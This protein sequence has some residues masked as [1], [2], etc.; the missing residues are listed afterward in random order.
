MR[1]SSIAIRGLLLPAGGVWMALVGLAA[2]MLAAGSVTQLPTR[3]LACTGLSVLWA[4]L[5]VAVV[6]AGIANRTEPSSV[7]AVGLLL[8]GSAAGSLA[9]A[10]LCSGASVTPW[11]IALVLVPPP[12]VASL[13]FA[14]QS[15]HVRRRAPAA[16]LNTLWCLLIAQTILSL[17]IIARQ[18]RLQSEIFTRSQEQTAIKNPPVAQIETPAPGA[19]TILLAD[20]AN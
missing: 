15:T 20:E 9:S 16:L 10:R 4:L 7:L 8:L 11:L 19:R 2:H 6:I 14:V 12:I 13:A 5:V 18:A 1:P 3:T 17:P